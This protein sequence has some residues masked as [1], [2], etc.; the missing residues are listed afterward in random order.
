M[1]PETTLPTSTSVRILDPEEQIVAESDSQLI[2]RLEGSQQMIFTIDGE[3]FIFTMTLDG[4]GH[5]TAL[6]AT[7]D[8]TTYDCKIKLVSEVDGSQ[9]CCIPG[10]SCSPGSC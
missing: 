10:G 3:A 2:G 7:K 6:T 1:K 8:N 5:L 9:W 4:Q